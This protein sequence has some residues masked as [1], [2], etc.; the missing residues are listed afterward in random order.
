METELSIERKKDI[1]SLPKTRALVYGLKE[2]LN[3]LIQ[4]N[5]GPESGQMGLPRSMSTYPSIMQKTMP[6]VMV[7]SDTEVLHANIAYSRSISVPADI[8]S[9]AQDDSIVDIMKLQR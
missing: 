9:A 2:R 7:R 4:V 6:N 5:I 1:Q 8:K 3:L